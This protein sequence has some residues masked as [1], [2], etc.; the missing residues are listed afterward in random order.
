LEPLRATAGED[1]Y[2]EALKVARRP[3]RKR[4][5]TALAPA[6]LAEACARLVT[7][8]PF[9]ALA[10]RG[11]ASDLA[12]ICL[13]LVDWSHWL[14][15]R[16]HRRA[17]ELARL[18]ARVAEDIEPRGIAPKAVADLR[19]EALF[20]LGN[21]LKINDRFAAAERT[22]ARS[23]RQLGLG[24]GDPFLRGRLLCLRASSLAR[25]HREGLALRYYLEAYRVLEQLEEPYHLTIALMGVGRQHIFLG[26]PELA[27]ACLRSAL[28]A[29]GLAGDAELMLNGLNNIAYLLNRLGLPEDAAQILREGCSLCDL[30]PR[31]TTLIR[32]Q[33]LQAKILAR[34]G[35]RSEA[36]SI[37][38]AARTV[39]L[40]LGLPCDAACATLELA[41]LYGLE[42]RPVLMV[43]LASTSMVVFEAHGI[44]RGATARAL[45]AER[46]RNLMPA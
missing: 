38:E 32:L 25:Q 11:H 3:S 33:T 18:A 8:G 14:R 43:E 29:P 39:F 1:L 34:M 6:E 41:A 46:I 20:T 40:Q 5:P 12:E 21:A 45:L 31:D 7:S 2:L 22:F 17:L 28:R 30:G 27:L 24:T 9:P 16:Q 36:I 13:T 10:G 42:G 23:E 19:A 37:F 35:Y 44:Y 15:N 26:H 4:P